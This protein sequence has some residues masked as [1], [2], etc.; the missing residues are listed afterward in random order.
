MRII[1]RG[2]GKAEKAND[3]EEETEEAGS[4]NFVKEGKE[5]Q[6]AFVDSMHDGTIFGRVEAGAEY[7]KM[8]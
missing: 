6:M 7:G 8:D 2:G 4:T 5:L 1:V 3:E